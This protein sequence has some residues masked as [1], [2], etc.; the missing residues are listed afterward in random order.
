[1]V[2]AESRLLRSKVWSRRRATRIGVLLSIRRRSYSRS[3]PSLGPIG[4]R[5]SVNIVAGSSKVAGS[6]KVEQY[7]YGNIFAHDERYARAEEFLAVCHAFWRNDGEVD[8][9]GKYY[10][11]ERGEF[12]TPFQAARGPPPRCSRGPP[13]K[14]PARHRHSDSAPTS[15]YGSVSLCCFCALRR[16]TS[17]ATPGRAR[18]H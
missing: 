5:L 13:P 14:A 12:Y 2:Q 11:V 1:M 16:P 17:H 7:G 3:I 6:A 18:F 9:D 8:F 15:R 4:G 10:R